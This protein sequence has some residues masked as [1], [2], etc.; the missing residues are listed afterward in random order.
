MYSI[1][2]TPQ[3]QEANKFFHKALFKDCYTITRDRTFQFINNPLS[4]I[5]FSDSQKLCEVFAVF[6]LA[7]RSKPC[8][9]L[10][11]LLPN[12]L[13]LWFL[14][15]AVLLL[16]IPKSPHN[17]S[18]LPRELL[19]ESTTKVW[20]LFLSIQKNAWRR[21]ANLDPL[22]I[23]LVQNNSNPYFYCLLTCAHAGAC[24]YKRSR[25]S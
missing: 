9:K 7:E 25:E 17:P 23:L 22:A 1:R 21:T 6:T 14:N 11:I 24:V 12:R 3:L 15:L 4:L 18:W 20:C 19:K 2:P 16:Q 5:N 8:R 10:F 13:I